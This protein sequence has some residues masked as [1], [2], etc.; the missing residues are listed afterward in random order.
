MRC[1]EHSLLYNVLSFSVR[2]YIYI[3][4]VSLFGILRRSVLS[5]DT[6]LPCKVPEMFTR[7][8]LARNLIAF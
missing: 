5:V 3:Y 1:N 2:V 6:K 7:L 8:L 4:I